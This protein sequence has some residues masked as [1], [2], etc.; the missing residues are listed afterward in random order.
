MQISETCRRERTSRPAASSSSIS[1]SSASG[2]STTPLPMKHVT[3]SCMM[4]DGIRRRIVFLPLI[5][6]VWPALWPPWKRTTPC[7]DSASQ[8]TIL[9]LPSS[10]HW[11]PITTTFLLILRINIEFLGKSGNL[12]A[13]LPLPGGS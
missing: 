12:P 2:D 1:L 4:P 5:H 10:P 3:P 6:S 7:T 9:P 13:A 8:S 11:V